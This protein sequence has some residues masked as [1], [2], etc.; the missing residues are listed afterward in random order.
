MAAKTNFGF[1]ILCVLSYTIAYTQTASFTSISDHLQLRQSAKN[2]DG[3][4]VTVEGSPYLTD[5]FIDA[6]VF[7]A[8]GPETV[9]PVRYNIYND[10][11]EYRQN[12]QTFILNPSVLIDKIH[13]GNEILLVDK[14]E[15]KGKLKQG[16]FTLLDSGKIVL[17]SKKVVVY[18]ESHGIKAF[19]SGST[20]PTY[21]RA[22][23]HYYYKI[24]G[25]LIKVDN[26]KNVITNLPNR[27]EEVSR[28][29]KEEKISVRKED[30]LVKLFRYYNS[31]E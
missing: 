1:F 8:R 30:E 3:D 18:K 27:R 14:Y 31:L 13:L 21:T 29:A 20:L 12:D 17:L 10:Y 22:S 26:L 25:E 23:N 2:L 11:I 6:T 5:A 19:E 9:L 16:Y 28:F 15:C 7:F 4:E 24:N